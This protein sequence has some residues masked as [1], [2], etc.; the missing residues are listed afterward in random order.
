MLAR[1]RHFFCP[2]LLSVVIFIVGCGG[3]GGSSSGTLNPCCSTGGTPDLGTAANLNGKAVFPSDNPWNQ[4]ID[5]AQVDPSSDTLINSIGRTTHLHPDFGS[6]PTYGIPYI[7]VS[8]STTKVPM[9]F[10]YSSESDPGPY[11]IPSNAP[12]EGGSNSSGDRHILV[13]DRDNWKLY[14]TWNTW[15]SGGGWHAGSGAEFDLNSNTLRPDGWTSADA[16]GL[17]IFPGLVRYEEV[18]NGL[19]THAIRFTVQQSRKAYVYP[20]RHCAS[21]LTSP[22]YPP[23]G[24]RV[25]LKASVD[26]S[27]YPHDAQVILQAMKTYGLILAD[28]G[29]NWF[30]TGSTDSRW[31]DNQL[32]TI[33]Q[34]TGNDFEVVKMGEITTP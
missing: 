33:K 1:V 17:P 19:I 34:L 18:K 3:G 12:I 27:G 29:S 2:L 15:P 31:D 10:D 5:T 9:T 22:S 20:A 26:I 4:R 14:E 21:S 11:P 32:N 13:I 30:F 7:I 28:N 8:G 23:M 6:D 25:R 24:M 16:A